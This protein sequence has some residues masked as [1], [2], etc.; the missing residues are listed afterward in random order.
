MVPKGRSVGAIWKT[1]AKRQLL[2]PPFQAPTAL[3]RCPRV[4]SVGSGLLGLLD[5][6]AKGSMQMLRSICG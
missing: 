2:G 5:G 4:T 3:Y 1:A 6:D